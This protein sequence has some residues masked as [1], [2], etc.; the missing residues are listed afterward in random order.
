MAIQM[1]GFGMY[2]IFAHSSEH[3]AKTM[4]SQEMLAEAQGWLRSWTGE[5]GCDCANYAAAGIKCKWCSFHEM[6]VKVVMHGERRA[7]QAR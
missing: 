6:L 2:R 7:S 1:F 3:A 4:M 5:K